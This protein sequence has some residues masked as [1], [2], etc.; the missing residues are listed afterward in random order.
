M[1]KYPPMT[2]DDEFR[3]GKHKGLPLWQ[4]IEED[5]S[6]ITWLIEDADMAFELDNEAWELYQDEIA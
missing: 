1:S 6:Y 5:P 2:P 4:V 3:F